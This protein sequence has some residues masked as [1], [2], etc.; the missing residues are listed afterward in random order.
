MKNV[1]FTRAFMVIGTSTFASKSVVN[2]KA[3]DFNTIT[4]EDSTFITE[5]VAI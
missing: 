2:S 4:I 1:F 3:N 5:L